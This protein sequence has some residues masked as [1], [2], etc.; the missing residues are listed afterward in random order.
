M[1]QNRAARREAVRDREEIRQVKVRIIEKC[2][3]GRAP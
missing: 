3:R 1:A 2:V